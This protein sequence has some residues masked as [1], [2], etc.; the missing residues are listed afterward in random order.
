MRL[1]SPARRS[2][3]RISNALNK[4]DR[5]TGFLL[6]VG[7]RPFFEYHFTNSINN[8]LR[9]NDATEPTESMI[10][11]AT[12]EAL[13]RTWQ[14]DN[15]YTKFVSRLRDG[16]NLG[17]EFGV[18][19]LIV[20][21]T[22]TPANL[23]KALVEYSPVGLVSAIAFKA[24]KFMVNPKSAQA[25]KA[26]V[27]SVSKGITGTLFMAVAAA[28]ANAGLISG[29]NDE[30]DKDLAAFEQNV[31]GIAPYSVT[32]DGKSYTYD[33]AQPI[34]GLF[35][36]SADFIQNIK[37]GNEPSV[38]GMDVLGTTANAILN[39]MK[40]TLYISFKGKLNQSVYQL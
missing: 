4:V 28:L 6:D 20:P 26:F 9:L 7:D 8:Q 38:T 5:I 19:S 23:T 18:G 24:K 21:F 15:G 3:M 37:A 14:D 22:K 34:G 11:I 1:A 2:A 25:Q 17:K 32:V 27:D 36:I 40:Y 16:L 30:K 33:W 29:G 12:N 13:Q 35:A 39:D 31:M 10:G